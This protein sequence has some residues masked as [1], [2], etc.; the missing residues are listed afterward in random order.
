[1]T[2]AVACAEVKFISVADLQTI[3]ALWSAASEGKFGYRSGLILTRFGV[4]SSYRAASPGLNN[5]SRVHRTVSVVC[6]RC[7]A[8]L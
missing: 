8:Q 6:T 5:S 3:D 1:M 4:D 7:A 2:N